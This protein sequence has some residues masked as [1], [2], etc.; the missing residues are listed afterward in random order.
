MTPELKK[1]HGHRESDSDGFTYVAGK[2][3]CG[4]SK[5]TRNKLSTSR[6]I[7]HDKRAV[8]MAETKRMLN[9]F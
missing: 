5:R 6:S 2:H 4:R 7:R 8:K 9:D 3:K 1:M